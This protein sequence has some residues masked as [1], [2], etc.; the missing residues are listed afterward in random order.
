MH[1]FSAAQKAFAVPVH[2]AQSHPHASSR[3]VFFGLHIYQIART[4]HCHTQFFRTQCLKQH[5][6]LFRKVQ[7]LHRFSRRSC[8]GS[9]AASVRKSLTI[10]VT[11]APRLCIWRTA[12]KNP[13]LS[14]KMYVPAA[15]QVLLAVHSFPRKPQAEFPSG[16]CHTA[17]AGP[18]GAKSER[19]SPRTDPVPVLPCSF[20]IVH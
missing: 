17:P 8:V 13:S 2:S 14:P 20:S 15:I 5:G 7:I 1:F 6:S 4:V 11:P 10:T 19:Q 12:E 9:V 3:A 18:Y 16:C